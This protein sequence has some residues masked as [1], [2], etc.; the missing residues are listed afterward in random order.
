MDRVIRFAI[1]Q[2]VPVLKTL[3]I[4]SFGDTPQGTDLFFSQRHKNENMLVCAEDDVPVAMLSMLPVMLQYNAMPVS[5]RHI[6]GVGTDEKYRGQGISTNL[7][8]AAHDWMRGRGDKAAVLAPANDTLFKFYEKRG[9]STMFYSDQLTV[10]GSAIAEAPRGTLCRPATLEHFAL[11]RDA[12]HMS[13]AL[14]VVWPEDALE[15][16]MDF[17]KEYGGRVLYVRSRAGE[18]TAV[19]LPVGDKTVRVT[20]V[21]NLGLTPMEMLSALHT[22]MGAETYQM[23]LP[24]DSFPGAQKRP[25]GMLHPLGELPELDGD[26][27]YLA[28]IKD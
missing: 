26:K 23:H 16:Y 10:P 21:S 8:A 19:C 17:V 14:F 6:Y 18:G 20:D 24:E 7:L 11:F 5:G 28:L 15:Y 9:Y 3:W 25:L 4:N 1:P 27:P 13:S 22:L 12:R 2:D